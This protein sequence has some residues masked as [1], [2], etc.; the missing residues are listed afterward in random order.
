MIVE[1]GKVTQ[2]TQGPT[3]HTF[4]SIVQPVKLM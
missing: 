2:Q 1:L 3:G 4:E